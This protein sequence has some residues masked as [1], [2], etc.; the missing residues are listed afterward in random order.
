[1]AAAQD[2]F[3]ELAV[4]PDSNASCFGMGGAS[5][6]GARPIGMSAQMG[7]LSLLAGPCARGPLHDKDYR[8]RHS[9][10]LPA[11]DP[12][13]APPR[14]A[15]CFFFCFVRGG[16]SGKSVKGCK[17]LRLQSVEA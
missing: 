5:A 2:S 16:L 4:E 3:P 17:V 14:G 15:A 1:M 9:T 8:S 10:L 12:Q 13:D 7:E 6:N 11:S